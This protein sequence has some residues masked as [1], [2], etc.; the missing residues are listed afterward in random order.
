MPDGYYSWWKKP[1][2]LLDRKRDRF[3]LII[4]VGV[5][6]FL[7]MYV[8][9][10]FNITALIGGGESEHLIIFLEFA[11]LTA[12]A[13]ALVQFGVRA[14]MPVKSLTRLSFVLLL[15]SELLLFTFMMYFSFEWITGL[16]TEGPDDFM[17]IFRY[18]A[19]VMIIP[20]TAVLFYVHHHHVVATI[21]LAGD[22]L[23]RLVDENNKLQLAIAQDQLLMIQA[24]DNYVTVY[25][26]QDGKV[27]KQL[28][29]T[30]LKKLEGELAQT[31]IVRCSRSTMVN[32]HNIESSTSANRQLVVYVK[33]LSDTPLKVSRNYRGQLL[34]MLGQ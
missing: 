13:L 15:L 9:N 1:F 33:N 2:T 20:Y 18:S 17:R 19:L 28:I 6:S 21:P 26:Q 24:A 29:R 30:S 22:H 31:T 5:F 7:F 25:H 3:V 27:A 4:S 10:P 11:L 14:A 32:I 12:L 23:I 34:A 16:P 8:Y